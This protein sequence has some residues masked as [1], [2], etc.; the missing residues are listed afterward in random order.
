MSI[1]LLRRPRTGDII[2]LTCEQR[3]YSAHSSDTRD[4]Q[5]F[6]GCRHAA[7]ARGRARRRRDAHD[8]GLLRWIRAGRL[9]RFGLT[10]TGVTPVLSL[11]FKERTPAWTYEKRFP[12]FKIT[13]LELPLHRRHRDEAF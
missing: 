1:F 13:D 12:G 7:R 11:E 3:R 6:R 8:S 9:L 10:S 4:D 2:V 5:H